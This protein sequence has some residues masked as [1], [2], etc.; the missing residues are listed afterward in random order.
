VRNVSITMLLFGGEVPPSDGDTEE[1]ALDGGTFLRETDATEALVELL[2]NAFQQ[3]VS[4]FS[5]DVTGGNWGESSRTG[6]GVAFEMDVSLRLPL[7]RIDNE[8]VTLKGIHAE[9]LWNT[10]TQ[11]IEPIVSISGGDAGSYD[12]DSIDGGTASSIDIRAI[13]GGGA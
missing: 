8:T 1:A 2:V 9:Q 11:P 5:Y 6:I 12:D 10:N 7:V 13:N 3:Q 4:Q